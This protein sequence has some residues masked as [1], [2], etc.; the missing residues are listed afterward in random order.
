MDGNIHSYLQ[1]EDASIACVSSKTKNITVC[2][3]AETTSLFV[4][5]VADVRTG[6]ENVN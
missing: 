5:D 2:S 4:D 6:Q 1:S 3:W